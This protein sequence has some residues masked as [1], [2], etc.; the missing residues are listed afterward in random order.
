MSAKI[1][2]NKTEKDAYGGGLL[3]ANRIMQPS[4][5][6][7]S[8]IL[9]PTPLTHELRCLNLSIQILLLSRHFRQPQLNQSG[10]I[11]WWI[12]EP[13]LIIRPSFTSPTL[14]FYFVFC[15]LPIGNVRN[16][17]WPFSNKFF[18]DFGSVRFHSC[19]SSCFSK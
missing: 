16:K 10:N 4:E 19:C 11:L 1:N 15:R 6:A 13:F 8:G 9:N 5:S 3:G 14:S 18:T 2:I 12:S 17:R 7:I